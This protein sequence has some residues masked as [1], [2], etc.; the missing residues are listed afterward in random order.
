M[1]PAKTIIAKVTAANVVL[2]SYAPNVEDNEQLQ[3][4]FETHPE[5]ESFNIKEATSQQAPVV[6]LISKGPKTG[7]MI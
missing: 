2:H 4:M 6:R 5:Q 1:V 7:M 3:Q